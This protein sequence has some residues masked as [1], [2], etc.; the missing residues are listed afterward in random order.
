MEALN[1]LGIDIGG[2]RI[3]AAVLSASGML[4]TRAEGV[5]PAR[6]SADRVVAVVAE[7]VAQATAGHAPETLMAAGVCAPGPLDSV[8][9]LA[10]STPTIDG[11]RDYPLRDRIAAA[12]GMRCLLDHDGQAAAFGEW[13]FGAG[14]GVANMV[15]VTI[16]TGIGG[17]AVVDGRLQRGRR[18]M[19][20][21]VGHMTI[22]PEGPLCN[23]GNPG[24]WEA[25]AAGPAFAV[26]ARAAGFADGEAAFA[27]ARAGDARA[28]SVVAVEA[29][30]LAIGIVNLIHIYSP[31]IVVLG[32][33]VTAGLDVMHDSLMREIAARAMPPFQG[34]P[35]TRA[36]LTDNA[37]LIGA[38][39]LARQAFGHT[40]DGNAAPRLG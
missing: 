23:C 27:A 35:V 3:R 2:S 9:G 38:A 15:Y 29:R 5:T 13:Q 26:A 22:A 12:I 33:G 25:F 11:F 19:A 20:A 4:L 39:A 7:V 14:Q 6:A 28:Q 1:T 31:D 18:G 21:H 40:R 16:S 34:V 37:G 8:Q 32:G 30:W 17:G 24:C 36:S 10:L